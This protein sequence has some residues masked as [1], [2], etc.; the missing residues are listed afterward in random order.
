[1]C[2]I[3]GDASWGSP[4]RAFSGGADAFVAKVDPD[5][6]LTWNT[7]LGGADL[8]NEVNYGY[9]VAVDDSANVY[10]TGLSSSTWGSPVRPF[11]GGRDGFV[12]KLDPTGT[13]IWNTFLGGSGTGFPDFSFSND[14]A[15]GLAL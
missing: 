3:P 2:G 6:N 8:N 4:V 13:L 14:Y 5:G 10:V 12:A 15:Y 1:S 11:S 7:F 9:G